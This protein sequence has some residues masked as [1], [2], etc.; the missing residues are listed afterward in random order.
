MIAALALMT[1]LAMFGFIAFFYLY[2]RQRR[3]LVAE[4]LR[5]DKSL[6][7]IESP[8]ASAM[9]YTSQGNIIFSNDIVHLLM[10]L[11]ILSLSFLFRE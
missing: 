7:L 2:W 4:R 6:D 9:T 3:Q 10:P 11:L 8:M 1:S 5:N